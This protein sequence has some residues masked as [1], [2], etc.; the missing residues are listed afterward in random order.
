MVHRHP[1]NTILAEYAAGSLGL[2][3]TIS[4]T[5]HL[6][7][8]DQC[9]HEV[10]TLAKIGGEI[11]AQEGIATLSDGLFDSV[12][13]RI[14]SGP[15]STEKR[16]PRASEDP[17]GLRQSLPRYVQKFLPTE[18]LDWRFLSP[19][20]KVSSIS[21]GDAAHELALHRIAAGGKAP[22]HDHR[23]QEITVVLT[24]SFSDEDGVYQP[25]DFIVRSPG[26][27]HR[28]IAAQNEECVCLSVLAAPI[29]LTGLKRAFN[30]FLKF[31]PG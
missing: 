30:P 25:G 6:Q 24:G 5:T 23:G 1:D 3:P 12:L 19:S 27:V 29:K 9:E 2:A 21:V 13:A 18:Q 31:S 28:P 8:C 14:D 20:L 26:D 15:S 22:Q 17:D 4:V 16:T 11:L 10:D 7:Y